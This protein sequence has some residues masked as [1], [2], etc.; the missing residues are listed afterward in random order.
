MDNVNGREGLLAEKQIYKLE[1]KIRI[2]EY[3]FFLLYCFYF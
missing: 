1:K 2:I 3:Y